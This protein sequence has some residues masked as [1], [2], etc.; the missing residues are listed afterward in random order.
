MAQ[1]ANVLLPETL[2]VL[3]FGSITT[4]Y[5]AV[6]AAYANPLRIFR[7][8]NNTDGDM[9]FSIDAVHDNYFVPAGS[10]VLYDITGNSGMSTNARIQSGTQFYV[11]YSGSPSKNSVYIEAIYGLGEDNPPQIPM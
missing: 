7:L 9:F 4:S 11:K 10:F 1:H 8:V 5:V 2:R 6:G 3:A